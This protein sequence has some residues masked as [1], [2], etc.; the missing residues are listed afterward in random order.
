MMREWLMSLPCVVENRVRVDVR[1]PNPVA[2]IG[3]NHKVITCKDDFIYFVAVNLEYEA[4]AWLIT[5]RNKR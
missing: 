2:F 5:D 1:G 3:F 4:Y